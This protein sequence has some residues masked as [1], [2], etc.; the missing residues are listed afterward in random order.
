MLYAEVECMARQRHGRNSNMAVTI[1]DILAAHA[2]IADG[3]YYSPCP[4][5][6][7]LSP[8]C[9]AKVYC[10]LEYLQR[11][12]SFKERGARNALLLLDRNQRTRGVIAASAGNHALG[13]AY[14]GQ[15]LSIGVTVVM[16]KQAPLI[17]V[18]TCRNLAANVILHGETYGEALAHAQ[19]LADKSGLRFIHGFD[20]EAIIAGQGTLGLEILAQVPDLEAVVIPVGGGGLIAGVSLAIKSHRPDVMIVGV[21]AFHTPNFS[22]ALAAGHPVAYHCRPTLADGLAV[23]KA[24]DIPFELARSRI[25]RIVQVTEDELSTAVLRLIE[26]EKS[27]VEGAGAAPLAACLGGRVPELADRRVV[28]VLCGGNIDPTMLSRVIEHGLVAD[29]RLCRFTA[30]ISDRPGGLAHLAE[31]IASTGASVK[32]IDHDRAFSGSDLTTV[33]VLCT[34]ETYGPA[35]IGQLLDALRQH[36]IPVVSR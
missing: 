20:D 11:T 7:Q 9:N 26:L 29:G 1:D 6:H 18:S 31:T 5:S 23:G 36:A 24:G 15:L 35:H 10:K 3:I 2:R 33:N 12:G 32:Q 14:H 21:E 27:V 13:L 34:V 30:T 8:L 22:T 25:D 4:E 17:K 28:L 16:P 19:A